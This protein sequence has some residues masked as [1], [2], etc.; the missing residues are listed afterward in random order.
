MRIRSRTDADGY[1][2]HP[3]EVCG[4]VGRPK[5]FS[6]RHPEN[7]DVHKDASEVA[8]AKYFVPSPRMTLGLATMLHSEFP[9][10]PTWR[11]NCQGVRPRQ[12]RK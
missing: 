9:I 7:E 6:A 4:R 12:I 2:R 8:M 3:L 1:H 10:T 5:K 11:A